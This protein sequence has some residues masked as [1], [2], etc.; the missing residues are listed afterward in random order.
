MLKIL[1]TL[2]YQKPVKH[3]MKNGVIFPTKMKHYL[4]LHQQ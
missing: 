4:L 3:F 2:F 1:S